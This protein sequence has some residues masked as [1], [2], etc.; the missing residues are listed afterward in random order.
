MF[1]YETDTHTPPDSVADLLKSMVQF[2]LQ[3][4]TQF[5]LTLHHAANS[6]RDS[7]VIPVTRQRIHSSIPDTG[8]RFLVPELT[9]LRYEV[10]ST[11]S[12]GE[13]KNAWSCTSTPITSWHVQG[14]IYL[15]LSYVYM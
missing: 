9:R 15:N 6:S 1:I 2:Q 3:L 10:D 5:D 7:S 14:H 12:S 13:V 8:K 11:P 4:Q